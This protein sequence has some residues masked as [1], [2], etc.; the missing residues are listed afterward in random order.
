[1]WLIGKAAIFAINL[2]MIYKT[3]DIFI[4]YFSQY[5]SDIPI[6]PFL[7]KLGFFSGLNVYLS[8]LLSG[9]V[10]KKIVNYWQ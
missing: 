6:T 4:Q 5:L 9:Y 1:M 10:V 7:C 8:M 2:A 3:I